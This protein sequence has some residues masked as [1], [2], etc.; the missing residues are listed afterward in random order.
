MTAEPLSGPALKPRTT[1]ALRA[2]RLL[3]ADARV[4]VWALI[5]TMGA[6]ALTLT[7]THVRHLPALGPHPRPAFRKCRSVCGRG[8][9]RS[10]A[11]RRFADT[12]TA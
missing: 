1:N 6:S 9:W 12:D 7:L 4:R 11:F 5:A 3:R 8:E 10:V 2:S